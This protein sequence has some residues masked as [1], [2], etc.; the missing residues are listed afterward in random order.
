MLIDIHSPNFKP[1]VIPVEFVVI[2]Y[3]G[4]SLTETLRLFTSSTVGTCA[5]FVID[6]GG[7][8]YDLGHFINGEIKRGAHAGE[9]FLDVDGK[10]WEKFNFFSIGIELV[11]LNGNLFSY[12][13]AQIASLLK[14][15]LHLGKR[16]ASLRQPERIVGHEHIAGYR[17]KVDPGQQF[18]WV[19][20]YQQLEMKIVERHPRLNANAIARFEEKHGKIIP[21]NM[22]DAQWPALSSELERFAAEELDR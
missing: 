3:T 21:T 17:G 13:D 14:L 1:E 15:L 5:H 16:F 10:R 22:T 8:T 4:C 2:H 18:D 19:S 11:N 20:L 6:I 9:S 12:P 7:A